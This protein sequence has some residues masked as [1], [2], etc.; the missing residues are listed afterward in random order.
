MQV[1]GQAERYIKTLL[2]DWAY[3]VPYRSSDSRNRQLPRWL[4]HYTHHRPHSVLSAAPPASK[5]RPS[6]NNLPGLHS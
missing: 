1:N 5:L 6:L 3:A 2:Q 4:K